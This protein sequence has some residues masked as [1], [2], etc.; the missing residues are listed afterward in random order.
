[1]AESNVFRC[2]VCQGV[3]YREDVPVGSV[4]QQIRLRRDFVFSRISR[5][6]SRAELKDLTDFMHGFATPLLA[7]SRCGTL[8]RKETNVRD[9]QAYEKDPNDLDLMKQLLPRYVT[10]FR[11]KRAAYDPLIRPGA[12]VLELGSHLGA[13]LQTAEEWGWR[14]VGL[15]VGRDTSAFARENGFRVHREVVEDLPFSPLTFDM[16]F[17]WNCFDQI[18]TPD[19]TLHGVHRVLKPNGLLVIR[20]PNALFYRALNRHLQADQ[21]D[22]FVLE[23]LAY[24]NLLGF[25]YLYGYTSGSLN[26]LLLRNGFQHVRGFNSELVTMPFPDLTTR[27][28]DEQ[29]AISTAVERWTTSTTLS[30][31]HLTGPWIEVVYRKLTEADWK[32]SMTHR[33]VSSALEL[34]RRSIDLRFL[35]RAA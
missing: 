30:S 5:S 28:E 29:I 18:E 24:N 8:I 14:A 31:G 7:C 6:A 34:P 12:D 11:H 3:S 9:A 25:P 19:A 21:S 26:S 23:A 17:I 15:D 16:V 4:R 32:R 1:M 13:F 35:E 33:P 20:V 2:P 27:I 10:A 22:P